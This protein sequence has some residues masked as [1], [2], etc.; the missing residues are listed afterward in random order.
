MAKV[1]FIDRLL[2]GASARERT[3]S[4]IPVTPRIVSRTEEPFTDAPPPRVPPTRSIVGGVAVNLHAGLRAFRNQEA[5]LQAELDAKTE[6][7]RQTRASI[8]SLEIGLA[9]ISMDPALN[10]EERAAAMEHVDTAVVETLALEL[11]MAEVRGNG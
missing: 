10:E 5:I 11:D 1:S 3:G 7:L 6:Q 9:E 2:H 8:R 4:V